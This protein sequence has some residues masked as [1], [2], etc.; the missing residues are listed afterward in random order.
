MGGAHIVPARPDQR[1][2]RLIADRI[3]EHRRQE[4]VGKGLQRSI[5]RQ[6]VRSSDAGDQRHIMAGRPRR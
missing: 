5:L 3:D 4:A 1:A 6:L 2:Q